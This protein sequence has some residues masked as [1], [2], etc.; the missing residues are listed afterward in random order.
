MK[1]LQLAKSLTVSQAFPT[2]YDHKLNDQGS[3]IRIFPTFS[4]D[5]P[6]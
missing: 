4:H 2:D 1:R 5:K 3:G 6:M